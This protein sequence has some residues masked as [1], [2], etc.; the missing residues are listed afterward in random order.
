MLKPSS[1]LTAV[2]DVQKIKLSK[3]SPSEILLINH[4]KR[5][6]KKIELSNSMLSPN[7]TLKCNIVSVVPSTPELLKSDQLKTEE[8]EPHP[9]EFKEMPLEKYKTKNKNEM[10]VDISL[11]NLLSPQKN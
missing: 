11:F 5:I 4:P 1:V 3:D 8:S 7:C 6:S 10:I 9:L 2:E